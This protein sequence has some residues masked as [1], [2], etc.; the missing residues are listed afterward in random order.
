MRITFLLERPTQFEAPFFRF[1]AR[2][3]EHHP[4]VLYLEAPTSQEVFDP[5]LG[6]AVSWGFDLLAGYEHAVVP[7]NATRETWST[8]LDAHRPEL[9]IVNGYTKKH[10]CEAARMARAKQVPTAL[11]LDSVLWHH[12]AA[13]RL[14][15]RLLFAVLLKPL[16]SRFLAVGS[17]TVDY[18]RAF[19]V[20]PERIDLF[21][22]AVD[23]EQFRA[24]SRCNADERAGLRQQFGLPA[25]GPVVLCVAK[26]GR[27]ESPWDV[28]RALAQLPAPRPFLALA[29]DGPER[30]ALEA[31]A[32][33]HLPETRFLGYV[34]Y[35]DLPRLYAA[36]DLFIHA[37]QEERWGVSVAE[38]MA[39]GLPV[40]TS[41]R[42]GA[43]YDLIEPSKNGFRY[44]L[45]QPQ[46]LARCLC[47]ALVLAPAVVDRTNQEILARWGYEASW[48][49][50]L[51]AAESCRR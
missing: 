45:G 48:R 12:T 14:A 47:E 6:R 13:R 49:G 46:E 43:G 9:L 10:Y 4:R 19:G 37:A 21:P 26:H 31:F 8:E 40:I 17:L 28:L 18:L 41:S 7:A 30:E 33:E 34:P 2:D 3:P 42:V 23:H 29:G 27:R 50:I 38:A 32:R 25:D 51:R 44:Q 11:R 22:Y 16:F 15:K 1:A 5:E 24:D 35:S 39:C 36:A 20:A